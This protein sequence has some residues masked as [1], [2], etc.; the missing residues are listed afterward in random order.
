MICDL[1]AQGARLAL[2]P[3]AQAPDS[4]DLEISGRQ[5]VL[6]AQ[7]VWRTATEIGVRFNGARTAPKP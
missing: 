4:F 7:T 3:G 2:A 5:Q 6:R 1:S